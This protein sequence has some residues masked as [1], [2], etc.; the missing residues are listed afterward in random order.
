MSP[1]PTPPLIT[2]AP[3][4][5]LVEVVVNGI[6]TVVVLIL[7]EIIALFVVAN[8]KSVLV[9]VEVPRLVNPNTPSAPPSN[10][11]SLYPA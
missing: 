9:V 2:N 6:D 11:K 5:V 7:K 8:S 1:I 3:V 4:L 10:V